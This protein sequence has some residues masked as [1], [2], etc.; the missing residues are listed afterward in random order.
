MPCVCAG[1]VQARGAPN[2]LTLTLTL[3]LTLAQRTADPHIQLMP[4]P[5]QALSPFT[6]QLEQVDAVATQSALKPTMTLDDNP[7]DG[8]ARTN[9]AGIA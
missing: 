8:G 2:A 4:L 1:H 7:T 9:A 3:T 6:R 5:R